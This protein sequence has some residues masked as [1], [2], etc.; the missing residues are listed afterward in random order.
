MRAAVAL[1]T[2][3]AIVLHLAVGCCGHVSHFNGGAV[4]CDG[5]PTSEAAG[6]CCADHGHDHDH[7][8][9]RGAEPVAHGLDATGAGG[10][11]G[12]IA[13]RTTSHDCGGCRCVAKTE[14]NRIDDAAPT[15]ICFLASVETEAVAIL[16]SARGLS[17][18]WDPPVAPGLRPQLF[19][20]LVV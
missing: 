19:E 7:G 11:H 6:D 18:T 15:A 16:Q 5:N 13:A 17:E 4:C 8:H 2:T 1:I 9:G 20:R 14:E 3:F 10:T 12:I